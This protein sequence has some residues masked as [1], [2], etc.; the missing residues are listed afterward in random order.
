VF[1]NR[2][3]WFVIFMVVLALVI[4]ARLAY[5]QIV[6]AEQ[7]ETLADNMITRPVRY[8]SAPRGGIFD[9]H[10]EL[11][12]SDEPASDI[13]I[14]YEVLLMLLSDEPPPESQKY[15]MAVGRALRARGRFPAEMPLTEIVA[16]LRIDVDE[17]WRGLIKL[18]GLTRPELVARAER[19]RWRVEKVKQAVQGRSRTISAIAEETTYH[20]ILSELDEDYALG[21]RVEMETAYPWLRVVPSSRRVAR[22]AESLVHLLGNV[23][24]ASQQRIENDPLATDELGGLQSGDRCGVSGVERLAELTLRGRRGRIVEDFDRTELE[25]IDPARG[26]DVQ[27]T[28]DAGLQRRIFKLLGR[29]VEKSLKTETPFGGAAAVVL[30]AQTREVLALVSYP[31]YPYEDYWSQYLESDRDKRWERFRFRAV[32]NGYPPGSTCKV[33]GLYGGFVE[34]VVT[35]QTPVECTGHFRSDMPDSF[36]CWIYRQYHTTHGVQTAED[37]IRNSCNIYF[38]TVGDRLG[39]DRLCR[40]FSAFGLGKTQGTGLIEEAVGIVPN[41]AWIRANRNADPTPR[42]A[43]AWNFAIGQ[44]EVTATP[45]QVANV[46]ASIATGHWESVKLLL[47]ASGNPVG[48]AADPPVRFEE[49]YL[50][51]LRKGMWRVIN[52][53]GGTAYDA[54]LKSEDFE[55]CGKT[56]SAQAVPRAIRKKY[57]MRWPDGRREEVIAPSLRE[58]L[59]PYGNEKPEV[60]G[61]AVYEYFPPPN[62]AGGNPSHAW[63]MAY[64]QPAGTP[65]GAAPRGRSYAIGLVL[66]YGGSGGR[67]AGPVAREIARM[68]NGLEV[69]GEVEEGPVQNVE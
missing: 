45:L 32:A 5:I 58:A 23:G 55:M 51:V 25:R 38:Y 37:A 6:R 10:G 63:F 21:I 15:L 48:E 11:L 2:L 26:E 35:P 34:G 28:I 46:A 60:V 53:R 8:L 59:A 69:D 20:P 39:V 31:A 43:D 50:Q 12:V 30:D 17:M 22:D 14:R 42:P 61:D 66:E 44:G 65:R 18:T 19:I 9:R 67:V 16:R 56:G 52:E 4:V 54:R 33:V 57:I 64:T 29:A 62:A 13:S 24:A 27:L 1:A 47:D 40:W 7:Y 3:R 49:R 41:S 68:V 36:R